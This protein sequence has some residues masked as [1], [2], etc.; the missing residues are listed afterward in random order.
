MAYGYSDSTPQFNSALGYIILL[1]DLF[2]FAQ[3]YQISDSIRSYY[4]TLEAIYIELEFH[5]V[6]NSKVDMDKLNELRNQC[7]LQDKDTLKDFHIE[8]NRVANICKLRNKEVSNT[9]GVI[10]Q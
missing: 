7:N 5:S 10:R 3:G 8:L 4:N 2:K 6:K 9:P 1:D